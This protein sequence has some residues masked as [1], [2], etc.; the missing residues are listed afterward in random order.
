M[1][2]V[3]LALGG[4]ASL[5]SNTRILYCRDT[6]EH[7]TLIENESICDEFGKSAGASRLR[8]EHLALTRPAL[9]FLGPTLVQAEPFLAISSHIKSITV[10]HLMD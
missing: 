2:H 10:N 9:V 5:G 1:D 3:V 4:I 8:T 7:P 6:F